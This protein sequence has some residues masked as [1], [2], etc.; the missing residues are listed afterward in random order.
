MK[1]LMFMIKVYKKDQCLT[2]SILATVL[3]TALVVSFLWIT[4]ATASSGIEIDAAVGFRGIFKLGKVSPLV[5]TLENLGTSIKGRLKIDV[6]EG[7]EY[8]GN[9]YL[10]T[11]VREVDL[12]AKSKKRFLFT[13]PLNSF[14]RPLIIRLESQGREIVSKEVDLRDHFTTDNLVLILSREIALD[15]L[16]TIFEN[17]IRVVHPHIEQLPDNP[18]GYDGVEAM[19]IHNL[20]LE[21]LGMNQLIAL[22]K[23]VAMGG[24]LIFSGGV[25]YTQY[26]STRL[27]DLMPVEVDGFTELN[28]L[29][30]L[31]QR[32]S[33]NIET[34]QSFVISK[35]KSVAGNVL[36]SQEEHPLIV[37]KESGRGRIIFLAFDFARYPTANW[38]GKFAMWKD[39]LALSQQNETFFSLSERKVLENEFIYPLLRLPVL[40]FPSHL[41]LGLFLIL[42]LALAGLFLRWFV[43]KANRPRLAWTL[44]AVAAFCF[45]ALGY[46]IFNQWLF[47]EDALFVQVARVKAL[48]G[49]RYAEVDND[50]GIFSTRSRRRNIRV[51]DQLTEVSQFVPANKKASLY[52]FEIAEGNSGYT[53]QD[54][55]L[56]RWSMRLFKMKSVLEFPME[57]ALV[58]QGRLVKATL[59]N[60]SAF[61]IY[62]GWM[63][64]RGHPYQVGELKAG[65]TVNETF[66]FQ[67]RTRPDQLSPEF[68]L[69]MFGVDKGSPQMSPDDRFRQVMLE[70]DLKRQDRE[71]L[72]SDDRLTF[73]GWLSTP[74]VRMAPDSGFV[75]HKKLASVMIT[76]SEEKQ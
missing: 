69:E 21:G 25:G 70:E 63:I 13:L 20:P 39:L 18:K 51:E 74:P 44:F 11:Y 9:L 72:Y 32:Y 65:R 35:V 55:H 76:L 46:W 75:Q 45:T 5:L 37:S 73:V 62:D 22:E 24:T 52:D 53:I 54:I 14:S 12:P 61:D 64:Y 71:N 17:K 28:S 50:V 67:A 36:L 40:P 7:S 66:R 6:S 49:S 1:A 59:T 38:E 33:R 48:A 68:W 27:K 60:S 41:E 26:K 4:E 3:I 43:Q 57:G 30:S 56:E 42:Y 58:R 29:S 2:G 15:F 31:G 8:R 16:S 47:K 34:P 19:V 10:T 23:W